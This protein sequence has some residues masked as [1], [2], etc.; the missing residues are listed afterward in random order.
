MRGGSFAFSS[1]GR[2]KRADPS[3]PEGLEV[4]FGPA[5]FLFFAGVAQ[6][7]L[8]AIPDPLL[9]CVFA[10]KALWFAK[11]SLQFAADFFINQHFP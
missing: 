8:F 5:S 7:I 11:K 2:K 10:F 4:G 1:A 3:F 9:I 6:R